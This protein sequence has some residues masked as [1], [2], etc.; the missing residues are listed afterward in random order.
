[1]ADCIKP[2]TQ[3]ETEPVFAKIADAA[4]RTGVSMFSI[5]QGIKN[6]TV[7][8]VRSGR[9]YLINVPAFRQMLDQES[10]SR[11]RMNI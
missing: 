6:G 3:F 8:Y 1:M 5:R 2:V 9:K 4:K 10:K 7:P 11:T